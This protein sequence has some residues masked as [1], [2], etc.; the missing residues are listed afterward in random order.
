M[1]RYPVTNSLYLEFV[2][3]GGYKNDEFWSIGR[4][5]RGTFLTLDAMSMGP[6]NWPND[7]TLP[8]GKEE[9]PV[10]RFRTSNLR[11]S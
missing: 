1:A 6:A 2:E 10:T 9:H 3:D 5:T 7:K 11:P 8:Q 4:Q